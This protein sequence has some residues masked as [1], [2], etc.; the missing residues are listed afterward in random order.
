[1]PLPVSGR[2]KIAMITWDSNRNHPG[3]PWVM[4]TDL[5]GWATD[6]RFAELDEAKASARRILIS[7]V[8]AATAALEGEKDA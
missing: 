7:F 1:M 4:R 5:P 2:V 3:K 8:K 6:R